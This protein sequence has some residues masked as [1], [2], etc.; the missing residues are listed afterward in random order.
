VAVDDAHLLAAGVQRVVEV[1]VEALERGL[2]ALADEHQLGCDLG[3]FGRARRRARRAVRGR[4]GAADSRAPGA[5]AVALHGRVAAAIATSSSARQRSRLP[6]AATSAR[7]PRTSPASPASRARG[8]RTVAPTTSGSPF[9]ASMA[10]LSTL[11]ASA[12]ARDRRRFARARAACR[13]RA[14]P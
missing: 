5:A 4:A 9:V 13:R 11:G 6:P 10:P 7:P 3:R 14:P 2:G 12:K 1:G 8:W